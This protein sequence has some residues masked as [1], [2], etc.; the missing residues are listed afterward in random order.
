MGHIYN[1]RTFYWSIYGFCSAILLPS[2]CRMILIFDIS[3]TRNECK[4]R[5]HDWGNGKQLRHKYKKKAFSFYAPS[6][7]RQNSC[8]KAMSNVKIFA[9]CDNPRGVVTPFCYSCQLWHLPSIWSCICLQVA[10]LW[11]FQRFVGMD[12]F[13]HTGLHCALPTENVCVNF[14]DCQAFQP[15]M[16]NQSQIDSFK[17]L[18]F[19]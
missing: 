12:W 8:W 6:W 9:D 2:I 18:V 4:A 3:F 14:R 13:E 5:R 15:S 10:L 16:N 19:S 1:N 11:H 7:K 17:N